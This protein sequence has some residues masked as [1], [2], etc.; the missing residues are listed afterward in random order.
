MRQLTDEDVRKITSPEFLN[1][2]REAVKVLEK[3]END[4]HTP[5]TENDLHR[6]RAGGVHVPEGGLG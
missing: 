2:L 6:L 4:P 3:L 5:L 1:G